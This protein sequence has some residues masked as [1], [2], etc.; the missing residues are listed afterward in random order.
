VTNVELARTYLDAVVARDY[1]RVE[2]LLADDFRLRDLS[3][4]GFTDVT[5][6]GAALSGLR[7]LLDRFDTVRLV[8][9][10]V[11][12]IGN[13]TYLRARLHFVHPEAGERLL[14]QH[15]LLTIADHRITAIDEL[16][17]GFFAPKSHTLADCRQSEWRRG[18]P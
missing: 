6:V 4:P 18:L 13:V 1:D 5:D 3:P 10:E 2:S 7:E 11:Y 16:C 17:T 8:D 9:S 12:D 15:H 14:E